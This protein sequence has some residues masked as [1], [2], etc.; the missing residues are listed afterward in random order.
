MPRHR[1]ATTKHARRRAVSVPTCRHVHVGA[2]LHHDP[3][4]VRDDIGIC[5]PA[6]RIGR[7]HGVQ[8]AARDVPISSQI[9]FLVGT[10]SG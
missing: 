5:H 9:D 7:G 3:D 2:R 6:Q 8:I 4:D 10:V 1:P